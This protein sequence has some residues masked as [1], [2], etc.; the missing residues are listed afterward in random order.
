MEN[1]AAVRLRVDALRWRV[2]EGQVVAV[3]LRARRYLTVEGAGAELWPALADGST[4]GDLADLLVRRFGIDPATARQ[5]VA[6][7]LT[8]LAARELLEPAP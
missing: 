8:D 4:V 6:A 3:D 2:V 1:A 7:L 5:D